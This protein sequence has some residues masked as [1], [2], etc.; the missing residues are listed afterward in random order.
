M[1]SDLFSFSESHVCE[2]L[3]EE[4]FTNAGGKSPAF[5]CSLQSR[6]LPYRRHAATLTKPTKTP[7][8]LDAQHLLDGVIEGD[9]VATSDKPDVRHHPNAPQEGSD[10]ERTAKPRHKRNSGIR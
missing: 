5:I 4:A 1:V 10:Y 8:I 3:Q 6:S 2:I 9:A 7:I